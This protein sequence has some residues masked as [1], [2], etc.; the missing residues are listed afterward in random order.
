LVGAGKIE[1]PS[2]E[3]DGSNDCLPY[4][5]YLYPKRRLRFIYYWVR[6]ESGK[7]LIV[8]PVFIFRV[9]TVKGGGGGIELVVESVSVVVSE[10]S[11]QAI[12]EPAIKMSPRNFF[13]VFVLLELIRFY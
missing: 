11:L 4:K 12:K 7:A 3:Q 1:K 2:R 6:A 9:S 5:K 13:I 8:S 10:V